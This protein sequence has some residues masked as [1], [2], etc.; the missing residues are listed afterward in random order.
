MTYQELKERLDNGEEV[1][2]KIRLHPEP[3]GK[4]SVIARSLVDNGR[5]CYDLG[6]GLWFI[7]DAETF[8]EKCKALEVEIIEDDVPMLE[9]SDE[10]RIRLE[11]E[12]EE[13]YM[14]L[15]FEK[16]MIPERRL[17]ELKYTPLDVERFAGASSNLSQYYMSGVHVIEDP[18][19]NYILKVDLGEDKLP[20]YKRVRKWIKKIFK[21][22]RV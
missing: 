3:Y 7:D 10:S 1:V 15:L 2:I 21:R 16:S 17:G 22:N 6:Y 19:K 12:L 11:R 5:K 13:L 4:Y 8:A 18:T 9:W 20:W 14:K